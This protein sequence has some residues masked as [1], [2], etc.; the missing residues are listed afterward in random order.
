MSPTAPAMSVTLLASDWLASLVGLKTDRVLS[1]A[2]GATAREACELAGLPLDEI[3][4]Y[5]VNG[6]KADATTRLAP[7][8]RLKVLPWIIGG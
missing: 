4:I 5:V 3:G 8:D 7:D 6:V 1:L 2:C